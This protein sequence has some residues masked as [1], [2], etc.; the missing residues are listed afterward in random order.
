MWTF[1]SLENLWQ[2]LRYGFRLLVKNPGFTSV[3]VLTLALG[4]GAATAIFS[5]V[6]GIVFR[7]LPYQNPERFVAIWTK[8]PAGGDDRVRSSMPD[9]NDWQSQNTVLE[10]LSA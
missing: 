5:V 4:I 3:A 10:G 6:Y 2:D 1:F 9:F 7:P 8:L